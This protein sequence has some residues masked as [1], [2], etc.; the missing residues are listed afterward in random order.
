MTLPHVYSSTEQEHLD[1]IRACIIEHG[2]RC[3]V[4]LGTFSG[5]SLIQIAYALQQNGGGTVYAIDNDAEAV[6]RTTE[7]FEKWKTSFPNV[8]LVMHLG[9]LPEAIHELPDGLEFV[10]IDDLHQGTHVA[11]ELCML[12]PK[13]KPGGTIM[14]HDTANES[15]I[16]K[17][18]TDL[19]GILHPGGFGLGELHVQ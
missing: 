9:V 15:T 6:R 5:G 17:A 19:G 1:R 10:F 8:T 18:F 12:L 13:M 7:S 4:E 3:A 16:G 2:Y 11:K 14:G